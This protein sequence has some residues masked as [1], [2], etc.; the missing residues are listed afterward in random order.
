MLDYYILED[1]SKDITKLKLKDRSFSLMGSSFVVNLNLSVPDLNGWVDW[2]VISLSDKNE[3]ILLRSKDKKY[4]QVVL[5]K[6]VGQLKEIKLID[7]SFFDFQGVRFSI[8]L[9][10]T[11]DIVLCINSKVIFFDNIKFFGY[12][13][14]REYNFR[15]GKSL[16]SDFEFD[17]AYTSPLFSKTK[18]V[19][20]NRDVNSI[21]YVAFFEK[22]VLSGEVESSSFILFLLNRLNLCELILFFNSVDRVWVK[23]NITFL[24]SQLLVCYK[25][26]SGFIFNLFHL[27]KAVDYRWEILIALR[28]IKLQYAVPESISVLISENKKEIERI[29]SDLLKVFNSE[30]VKRKSQEI[31]KKDSPTFMISSGYFIEEQ[32][33]THIQMLLRLSLFLRKAF[34]NSK[35]VVVVTGEHFFETSFLSM[36]NVRRGTDDLS[37]LWKE[38]V[39]GDVEVYLNYTS[40]KPMTLFKKIVK[41]V[42]P[43]IC[44]LHGSPVEPFYS[45]KL[46]GDIPIIYFPSSVELVPRC[47][48]THVCTPTQYMYDKFIDSGWEKDSLINLQ[49]PFYLLTKQEDYTL[50]S[51]LSFAKDKL[52]FASVV[53]RG[54]IKNFFSCLNEGDT[55]LFLNLFENNKDLIWFFIGQEFDREFFSNEGV[56]ELVEKKR[57]IFIPRVDNNQFDSFCQMLDVI[58]ALPDVSSGGN[59]IY[60]A[61]LSRTAAVVSRRSDVSRTCIDELVYN[62]LDGFFKLLNKLSQDESYLDHAS[63]KSYEKIFG[64]RDDLVVSWKERLEKFL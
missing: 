50:P 19:A 11:N 10:E 62:D 6:G 44:F 20:I 12:S 22:Y 13:K 39:G 56:L 7:F 36:W 42:M 30:K 23:K 63:R 60:R 24:V 18:N 46:L 48:V 8:Y 3:K 34:S 59:A 32:N 31:V 40:K 43:D 35:I 25:K 54:I 53:G 37:K 61:I 27:S 28:T 38:K 5:V 57:I 52:I 1:G 51:E 47:N 14:N 9:N 16:K 17:V 64:L 45:C 21:G 4:L 29:E 33:N 58:I 55:K 49:N 2:C 26:F 15:F 41:K